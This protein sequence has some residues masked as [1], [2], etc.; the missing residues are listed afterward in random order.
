MTRART[1]LIFSGAVAL[2]ICA[3]ILWF[4]FVSPPLPVFLP[5]PT[6]VQKVYET[7]W[8][9]KVKPEI[10]LVPVNASI[11]FLPRDQVVK[12]SKIKDA[13][14]NIVAVGQV[15][16]HSGK[17]TVFGT[18]KSGPDNV[19]RGG[20]EYRQEAT[21]FFAVQKEFGVRAGM[22]TGGLILGEIY[23]RPLRIGPVTVEVRGFGRRDDRN[24]ADFGAAVL[25]DYRF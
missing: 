23:A 12:A 9:G 11:E 18:L 19:L 8:R 3:A 10:R 24:G 15:P 14:D 17:T 4:S 2:G 13:P 16:P 21:P 22:G 25:A 20:L 5:G 7:K 1:V 6:S